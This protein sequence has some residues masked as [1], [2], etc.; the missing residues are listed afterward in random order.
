[1]AEGRGGVASKVVDGAGLSSEDLAGGD[2]ALVSF[3]VA[4]GVG[5]VECVVPDEACFGVLVGVEVEV[6]VLRQ[7][8]SWG[9]LV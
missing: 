6:G 8:K 1:M 2:G 4:G 3:E 9:M 7:Y 5:S